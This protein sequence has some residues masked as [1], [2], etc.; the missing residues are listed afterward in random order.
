MLAAEVN[1]LHG[2][3]LVFVVSGLRNQ[4]ASCD[5]K[6]WHGLPCRTAPACTCHHSAHAGHSECLVDDE[7]SGLALRLHPAVALRQQAVEHAHEV[8]TLAC[9]DSKG[10]QQQQQQTAA[11][12]QR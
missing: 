12:Q 6:E 10:A 11:W 4:T 8:K 1:A 7:L 2:M 9:L 5:N 3:Q